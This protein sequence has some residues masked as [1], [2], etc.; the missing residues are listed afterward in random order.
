MSAF[1]VCFQ[2][3][4]VLNYPSNLA[5]SFVSKSKILNIHTHKERERDANHLR[6]SV[7]P[8]SASAMLITMQSVKKEH[9]KLASLKL[10]LCSVSVW[11]TYTVQGGW[12]D[13][14]TVRNSCMN[15]CMVFAVY[16]IGFYFRLQ[17]QQKSWNARINHNMWMKL[18]KLVNMSAKRNYLDDVMKHRKSTTCMHTTWWQWL[19]DAKWRKWHGNQ[20]FELRF[21]VAPTD[22]WIQWKKYIIKYSTHISN[23]IKYIL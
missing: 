6:P 15:L 19:R 2:R 5:S 10:V 16:N 1:N 9:D 18:Q 11:S 23:I 22:K 17:Q 13:S 20:H 14:S 3:E 21:R 7:H 12:W 4:Y 8:L